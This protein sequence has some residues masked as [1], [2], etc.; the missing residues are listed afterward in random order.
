MVSKWLPVTADVSQIC[1]QRKFNTKGFGL[2]RKTLLGANIFLDYLKEKQQ[3]PL[4]ESYDFVR[5]N[6][7][8][9]HFYVDLRKPDGGRYNATS[10]ESIRN[11]LNKYLKSPLITRN[12]IS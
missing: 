9:A 10:F 6:E 8:L 12:L 5:L 7:R 3:D 1:L 4:F 11:G 2:I